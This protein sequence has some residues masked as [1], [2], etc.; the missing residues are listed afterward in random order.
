MFM[1]DMMNILYPY[2]FQLI[3]TNENPLLFSIAAWTI[4]QFSDWIFTSL[5]LS[6]LD[7]LMNTLLQKMFHTNQKIQNAAISCISVLVE[8]GEERLEG[9]Y[10]AIIRTICQCFSFYCVGKVFVSN[11]QER[12]QRSLLCCI[13]DICTVL[14][15]TP[16]VDI[17]QYAD[18][19]L[20]PIINKWSL[21]NDLDEGL[22]SILEC[23]YF[24]ISVTE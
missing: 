11:E 1:G 9:Y 23:L 21:L 7:L 16:N 3:Q 4:H 5:E 17:N 13:G 20:P 18:M 12:N 22:L 2:L 19:L 10:D 14:M 15:D 6:Q 24:L 8:N